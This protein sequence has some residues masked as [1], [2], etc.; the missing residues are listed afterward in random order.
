MLFNTR[1]SPEAGMMLSYLACAVL[2]AA[3]CG[4]DDG[5]PQRV[6]SQPDKRGERGESCLARNDCQGGLACIN[7]EC[8]TQNYEISSTP[9][10]CDRIECETQEDCCSN[11]DS[12]QCTDLKS[13]CDSGNLEACQDY[14]AQC[15]PRECQEGTCEPVAEPCQSGQVECTGDASCVNGRCVPNCDND[16]DCDGE[17]LCIDGQCQEGCRSDSACPALSE[18]QGNT[19]TEPQC[20]TNRECA[21]K[22]SA[23]EAVCDS[24][25]DCRVPCNYDA[26]CNQGDGRFEVCQ[27][28]VCV[29]AGCTSDSECRLYLDTTDDPSTQ[30]VCRQPP[31]Q[32]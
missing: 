7:G 2:L 18:C 24:D 13:E 27:D 30:A 1:S 3:G 26:E 28:G 23:P 11:A 8:V 6:Q 12:Q 22:E 4:G 19:C 29:F 10:Q 14:H 21:I 15:C 5:G 9:R 31:S 25:G 20:E 32:N 16:S 17:R